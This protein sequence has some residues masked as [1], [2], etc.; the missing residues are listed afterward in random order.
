[1]IKGVN[2]VTTQLTAQGEV[3]I[4]P[5]QSKDSGAIFD[6]E[7]ILAGG[8]MTIALINLVTEDIKESLD[9]SF[10][11]EVNSQVVGFVL[12]RHAYIG[13]P[14]VEVCL[15]QSLS[16]HPLHQEQDIETRLINELTDRVKSL[17]MKNIRVIL[18]VSNPRMEAF[19]TRLNFHRAPVIVCD[20]IL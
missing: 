8:S 18:S 15:I 6:M 9:L 16:I 11:A 10:I 13:A 1:L 3:K 17:G 2:N 14:A 5:M 12:A 7:R 19:F 20:K 4:R